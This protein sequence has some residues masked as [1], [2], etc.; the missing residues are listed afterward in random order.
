MTMEVNQQQTISDIKQTIV[1]N[2][3]IQEVWE[4][5]STAEGIASWFMKSDFEPKEGHGFHLQSPFGPSPC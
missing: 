5:V 2:V 1:L 3:P 4:K